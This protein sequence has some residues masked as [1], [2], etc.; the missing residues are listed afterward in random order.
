MLKPGPYRK[1]RL[2]NKVR[3]LPM[4]FMS[5]LNT[6]ILVL[7]RAIDG[8]EMALRDA[9]CIIIKVGATGRIDVYMAVRRHCCFQISTTSQEVPRVQIA[10][11]VVVE[12]KN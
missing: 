7:K 2:S 12:R 8:P 5:R 9:T 6:H 4:P 10:L 1:K 11:S 3:K